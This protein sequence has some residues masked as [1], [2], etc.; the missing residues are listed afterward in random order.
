MSF[1]SSGIDLSS[2]SLCLPFLSLSLNS[3]SAME[4]GTNVSVYVFWVN[5]FLLCIERRL[6]T[7]KIKHHRFGYAMAMKWNEKNSQTHIHTKFFSLRW[8]TIHGKTTA[9]AV[10]AASTPQNLKYVEIFEEKKSTIK[11]R[12]VF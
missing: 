9:I 6:P 4:P 3:V 2:L 5:M 10:V 11:K 1:D 7:T 8:E 12:D